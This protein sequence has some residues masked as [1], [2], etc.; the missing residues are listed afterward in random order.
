MG[1]EGQV[2][3]C[4]MQLRWFMAFVEARGVNEGAR[5]GNDGERRVSES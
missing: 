4:M 5:A 1:A 2:T 3:H